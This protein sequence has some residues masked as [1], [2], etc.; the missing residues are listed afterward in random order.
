MGCAR[1]PKQNQH[2]SKTIRT[3]NGISHQGE[4]QIALSELST[5]LGEQIPMHLYNLAK[6]M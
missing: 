1:T 4:Q 2:I 3:L 6:I 5:Y